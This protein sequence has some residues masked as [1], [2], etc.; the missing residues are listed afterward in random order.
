[1][2]SFWNEFK[3]FA[4]SGNLL[5]VAIGI[6]IGVAFAAVVQSLVDNLIMPLVAAVFGQ[7]DFSALHVDVN[8]SRL[9]YGTFLTDLLGFL[10]LALVVLVLVKA[11]KKATGKEAAGAQGNRE[12]DH[13]KSF[14]PVDAT[15][16]MFCTRDITPVVA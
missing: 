3:A 1:M 10:L 14:V 8:G 6:A 5:D 4:F 13:C 15:V 16:C 12:C 9:K 11:I 7:P 2:R